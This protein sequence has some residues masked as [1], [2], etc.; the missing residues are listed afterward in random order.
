[1]VREVSIL[2]LGLGALMLAAMHYM[3]MAQQ[4][5]PDE[6]DALLDIKKQLKDLPGSSFLSS[7]D[8]EREPCSG[9]SGIVCTII[10]ASSHVVMLNLG[11]GYAGSPG[12][13]GTL[14]P[15]IGD[16]RLLQQLTLTAGSVRGELPSSIGE[17]LGSSLQFLGISH[18]QLSGC[19]PASFASLTRLLVLDLSSNS[20]ACAIPHEIALLPSLV[21]LELSHN[22][23]SGPIP[24]RF[25]SASMTHFDLGWNELSG[26]IPRSLP[27]SLTYLSLKNNRLSG[28]MAPSL[29]SLRALTT[30]DLSSNE[31]T[32]AIPSLLWSSNPNLVSVQLQRN[33]LSG[34]VAIESPARMSR[35]DLSYN[36]LSG[37]IP[38][39]L[40]FSEN[41]F[42]N[43]NHFTGSVPKEFA[44][45]L[46]SANLRNLYLQHNFLTGF[47]LSPPDAALPAA[48]L[49]C[50]QYN[51]LTPPSQSACPLN[52]GKLSSRPPH[53][54]LS[55]YTP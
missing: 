14:S 46:L 12:L 29:A 28:S 52:A 43:N 42:L 6:R 35:V 47:D 17:N 11:D 13:T 8:F 7:W 2:R 3:A 36:N 22:K 16:L 30:L 51:C 40:A 54:C 23:L 33:H 25:T 32:G 18:N 53:Q 9:F 19:I 10:G 55:S 48:A 39:M 45:G 27:A 41:V 21:A 20:L 44:D 24:D 34:P 26:E 37:A 1:M 50:L 31:L 15:R 38:P 5:H 49:L 4:L